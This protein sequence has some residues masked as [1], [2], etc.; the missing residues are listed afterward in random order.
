MTHDSNASGNMGVFQNN[1]L[2]LSAWGL[3]AQM[4]HARTGAGC[5]AG[6]RHVPRRRCLPVFAPPLLPRRI[7]RVFAGDALV[8]LNACM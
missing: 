1:I 6:V 3:T 5:C 7:V 4:C 8:C 2:H